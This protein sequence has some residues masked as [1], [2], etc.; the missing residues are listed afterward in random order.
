[1]K[2]YLSMGFGVNSVALH[3]LMEDLGID[4]EAVFVDH[5]AD[6][7]ET[8]EYMKYFISTGRPVTILQP[9]CHRKKQN[10]TYNDLYE[11]CWEMEM[12]PSMMAR[13]CT[14]DFKVSPI[15]KYVSKPC[16]MH[17]GI[18]AG[19]SKRA[20][21]STTK[22][23][24]SRWLL[25]EHDI[26]RNGCK[27]LIKKNGLRV[28]PKSGC[29]FCPYQRIAQWKQLRM[30]HPELF[31]KAQKLEA[32]NMSSRERKGK[33]PLSLRNDGRTLQNIINDKQFAL[34]GLE[35]MEY[36]PCQCAL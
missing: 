23:I 16:W 28:P 33:K 11:Y 9:N 3:L 2:H 35:A 6:Y 29:W 13:W 12:V 24:E 20:R 8:Y 1:M 4:F 10:R 21:M 36:P 32:R 31:C 30:N 15:N 34:P 7:P 27:E 18:D 22:G 19:E 26:D 5:S 25:I 14:R 17:L